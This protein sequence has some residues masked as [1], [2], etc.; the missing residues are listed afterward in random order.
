MTCP[1]SGLDLLPEKEVGIGFPREPAAED[2]M[3]GKALP[4]T[5]SASSPS[6]AAA[7]KAVTSVPVNVTCKEPGQLVRTQLAQF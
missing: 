1:S 6:S 2:A 3:G 7:A 4:L 5:S